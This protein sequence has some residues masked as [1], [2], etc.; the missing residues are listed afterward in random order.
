M[1][2]S[3]LPQEY[4][5][6]EKNFP[7]KADFE[8]YDEKDIRYDYLNHMFIFGETPQGE[9]FWYKCHEAEQINELPKIENK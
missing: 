5:D 3:E 8:T 9:D 2:W 7:I 6:L 4:R 1:K